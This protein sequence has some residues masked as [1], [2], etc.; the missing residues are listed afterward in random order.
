[1]TTSLTTAIS[2]QPPWRSISARNLQ[3]LEPTRKWANTPLP[4]CLTVSLLPPLQ[5]MFRHTLNRLIFKCFFSI[6]PYK[7]HLAPETHLKVRKEKIAF[8]RQASASD[9]WTL[10]PTCQSKTHHPKCVLEAS[11]Q[12]WNFFPGREF[13][14]WK[15]MESIPL[16]FKTYYLPKLARSFK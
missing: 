11:L 5:I 14:D 3:M 6:I 12:I 15:N 8:W 1:M 4:V 13:S 7:N 2:S 9:F 16:S 10:C